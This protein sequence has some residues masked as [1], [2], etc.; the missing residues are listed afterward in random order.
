MFSR[1]EGPPAPRFFGLLPDEI[2]RFR[3]NGRIWAGRRQGWAR[4]CASAGKDHPGDAG[5]AAE[6]EDTGHPDATAADQSGGI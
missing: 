3:W 2:S 4:I 1:G 5:K 6:S